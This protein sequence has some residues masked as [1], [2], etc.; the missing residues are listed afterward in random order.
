MWQACVPKRHQTA[1]AGSYYWTAAIIL[2]RAIVPPFRAFLV[3]RAGLVDNLVA[4]SSARN[5]FVCGCGLKPLAQ[6]RN[7][8]S[9]EPRRQL[10]EPV[11]G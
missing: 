5:S 1:A 2:A 8:H 9:I 3:D 4:E 6:S 11:P 10:E 7:F